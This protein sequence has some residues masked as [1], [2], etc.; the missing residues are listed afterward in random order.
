[1]RAALELSQLHVVMLQ[2]LDITLTHR[3]HARL[4]RA[5]GPTEAPVLSSPAARP[6]KSC[7]DKAVELGGHMGLGLAVGTWGLPCPNSFSWV[8]QLSSCHAGY[9]GIGRCPVRAGAIQHRDSPQFASWGR[10]SF[11]PF[12][13]ASTVLVSCPKAL[14]G[15]APSSVPLFPPSPWTD[16]SCTA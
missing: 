1:M 4:C 16:T 3:R 13:H 6:A 15:S 8:L 12:A 7:R 9:E 5:A 2:G 10:S 14:A 11:L